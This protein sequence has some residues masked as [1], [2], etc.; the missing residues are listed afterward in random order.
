MILAAGLGTRLRPYTDHYAKPA[1]PFLNTPLLYYAVALLEKAGATQFV[2]NAH[3]KPEQILELS[4]NIPGVRTRTFVSVEEE[5]P[6]G[7]GGGV[8]Q[9]CWMTV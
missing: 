3:Y 1:L 8:W 9:R 2:I 5:K 6:L 4:K 7:S